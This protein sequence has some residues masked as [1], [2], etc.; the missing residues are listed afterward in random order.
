MIWCI[1]KRLGQPF[2][3]HVGSSIVIIAVCV[4]AIRAVT[5]TWRWLVY[6]VPQFP[7]WSRIFLLG[8]ATALMVIGTF[9]AIR[10]AVRECRSCEEDTDDELD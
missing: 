10:N 2:A 8:A 6:L 7:H 9:N 1:L 5:W 4:G 3:I